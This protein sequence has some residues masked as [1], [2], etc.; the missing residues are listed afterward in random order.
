MTEEQNKEYFVKQIKGL[1]LIMQDAEETDIFVA[2]S[3]VISKL[4]MILNDG[5]GFHPSMI[6]ALEEED[7]HD[8]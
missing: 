3:Y 7:G 4:Q 8:S 1:I 5:I 6:Q 2:R